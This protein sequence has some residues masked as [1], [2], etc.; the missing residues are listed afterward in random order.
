VPVLVAT[1]RQREPDGTRTFDGRDSLRVA[2]W[3]STGL[4]LIVAVTAV[5][6][7]AGQMSAE[8]GSILVAGGALTVLLLPMSATLLARED[9]TQQ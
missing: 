9:V 8:T 2:L 7:D 1:L 3:A 5:A 6:V 4:P